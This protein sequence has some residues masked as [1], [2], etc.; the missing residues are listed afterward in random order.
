M[1]GRLTDDICLMKLTEKRQLVAKIVLGK[2]LTSDV[3]NDFSVYDVTCAVCL[4]YSHY[5]IININLSLFHT[6]FILS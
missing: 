5:N 1:V 6:D 2:S 4:V 3:L